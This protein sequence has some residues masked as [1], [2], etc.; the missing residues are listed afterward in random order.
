[1]NGVAYQPVWSNLTNWTITLPLVA[2]LNTLA[3]QGLDMR[4]QAVAT[5]TDTIAVTNTGA[6]AFLPVVINEWMADN[7]GPGGLPDPADG[8]FQDWFE[9][10][11]P[12][13]AAV[14]LSGHY[15]TDTLAEPAKW[16]IPADIF[17]SGLGHLLVWADGNTNQNPVAG[18]TNLD[19]HANF[20]LNNSGEA[21]GL[22]AVDGVTPISTV[23]FGS[24][25]QNVSQGLFP[26]GDTNT[27]FFMTNW[28]PR[29]AN[30]LDGLSAPRVLAVEK[31]GDLVSLRC[32]VMPGRA[33]QL[34]YKAELTT[35][36]WIPSPTSPAERAA[37]EELILTDLLDGPASNRFYQVLL[38]P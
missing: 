11:N 18:G 36:L 13:P 21:L 35:P 10:F 29:A 38:L 28:T 5:A 32:Q 37:G 17:I 8:L 22:F 14:N 20:Q 30:T 16:Q 31:A 19:L 9:L 1:M 23:T 6:G 4:G 24:Q 26:D 25:V 33:Y 2:G 3:V 34:Q 15:L 27:L 12:N 7:K